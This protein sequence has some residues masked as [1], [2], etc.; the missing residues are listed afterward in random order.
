[1]RIGNGIDAHRF[2]EE[3]GDGVLRLGGVEI[4]DAPTLEGHSDA[5]V[6]LH[7]VADAILGAAALFVRDAVH[8]AAEFGLRVGNLDC[9]V[10]AAQPRLAP[11]VGAMRAR[12]AEILGADPGAVSVK[13]TS[14]DGMGFTGR[15]EGIACVATVLLVPA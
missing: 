13:A 8:R 11:H 4:P 3:Q 14:T 15:A 12:L 6:V 9:T 1:M 5:D 7:A 10:V 2:A